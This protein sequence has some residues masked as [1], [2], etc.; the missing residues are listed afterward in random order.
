MRLS[1][2]KKDCHII[3]FVD[4]AS[5]VQGVVC[6]PTLFGLDPAELIDGALIVSS[7]FSH[8]MLTRHAFPES[9]IEDLQRR[10]A[11]HDEKLRN[12][13]ELPPPVETDD[14]PS[15][16]SV[17]FTDFDDPFSFTERSF[18]A[19]HVAKLSQLAW[20]GCGGEIYVLECMGKGYIRLEPAVDVEGG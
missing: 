4:S 8:V 13:E 12:I 2:G 3:D 11:E 7:P 18:G 10:A 20:V 5:R 14:V 19:P 9:S 17:T 6:V 15:P 16:K 1:P